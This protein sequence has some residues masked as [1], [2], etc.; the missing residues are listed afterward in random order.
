MNSTIK[1]NI[2]EAVH[3]A[4]CE[5]T[6]SDGCGRCFH[7]ALAGWALAMSLLK[8]KYT[9]QAGS[10]YILA[11]PPDGI[12]AMEPEKHGFQRGEFHCWF[13]APG[14]DGKLAEFVDLSSRHYKRFVERNRQLSSVTEME[15]SSILTYCTDRIPWTRKDNPPNFIWTNGTFPDLMWAVPTDVRRRVAGKRIYTAD[16]KRVAEYF[17]IDGGRHLQEGRQMN[18]EY[19]NM[20]SIRKLYGKSS[21]AVGKELR[22]CGYRDK[23][24]RATQ[25]ALGS[26][27]AVLRRDELHRE[28][29]SVLWNKTKVCE[30]LEDFGWKRVADDV[31]AE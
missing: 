19:W 17:G 23:D 1:K 3:R 14:N 30:L 13:A 16:V 9:L 18:E 26:R 27:M 15:E 12:V 28:W 2:A 31:P 29:V 24:G 7:Y 10:L 11:D 6:N 5:F 21:F 8:K 25:K 22:D 20:K 4:V